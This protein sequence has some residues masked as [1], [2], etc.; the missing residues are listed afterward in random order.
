M[1]IGFVGSHGSG[2]TSLAKHLM[3]SYAE[4]KNFVYVPSSARRL[5]RFVP[6]NKEATPSSQLY[7]TASRIADEEE[8][9][10]SGRSS[11]LSDRTP[12]DSLAYTHY[13][14]EKVWAGKEKAL[15]HT[16]ELLV[17]RAMRD[18]DEIVYFP[19][20]WEPKDDGVSLA[21]ADYQ[22]EIALYMNMYLTRFGIKPYIVADEPVDKRAQ[23]LVKWLLRDN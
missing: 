15:M 5:E 2:K 12:L 16:S 7:I 23:H 21:D 11:I 22:K 20:Y 3:E 14:N 17:R 19:V 6:I 4:F 1:R 13:Q 18:Y 8:L 9:S 10:G